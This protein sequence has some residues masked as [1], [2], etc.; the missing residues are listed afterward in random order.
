M[1][2][3]TQFNRIGKH[4]VAL[5]FINSALGLT[6]SSVPDLYGACYNNMAVINF[7]KQKFEEATQK[8]KK[9]LAVLEKK[10]NGMFDIR[11]FIYWL[12]WH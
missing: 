5:N 4:D 9:G 6:N 10:V 1:Q 3:L 7:K 8:Q 12:Y 11:M 2:P